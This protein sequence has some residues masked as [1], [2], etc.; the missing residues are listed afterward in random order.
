MTQKNIIRSIEMFWP[1]FTIRLWN[2]TDY[3]LNKRKENV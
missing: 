1:N 3:I 2:G